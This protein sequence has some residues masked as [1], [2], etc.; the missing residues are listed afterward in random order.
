MAKDRRQHA[1]WSAVR[2]SLIKKPSLNQFRPKCE[3]KSL[4][5]LL[6]RGPEDIRCK[7]GSS[8]DDRCDSYR[9]RRRFVAIGLFIQLSLADADTSEEKLIAV[10]TNP[11]GGLVAESRV[12]RG[13]K[14]RIHRSSLR[15]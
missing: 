6:R 2:G 9:C 14:S 15:F 13:D 1:G 5:F 7:V 8:A 4:R 3:L 10:D 12:L 11:G